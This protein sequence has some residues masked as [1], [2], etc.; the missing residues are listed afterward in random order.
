MDTLDRH[1]HLEEVYEERVV[2]ETQK[3]KF[4]IILSK[5]NT[6]TSTA[7]RR[8]VVN[9]SSKKS[10]GSQLDVLK[11]GLNFAPAPRQI[12]IPKILAVVEATLCKIEERALVQ[13]ARLKITNR[14]RPPPP[15]LNRD[16]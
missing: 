10:T 16:E 9:L 12:P 14:S 5:K 4:D 11:R 7:E 2:K 1:V 3:R 13:R 15:N 6:K 8:W